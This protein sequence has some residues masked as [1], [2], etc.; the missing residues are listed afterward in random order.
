[1]GGAFLLSLGV[2]RYPIRWDQI[3]ASTMDSRVFFTLRLPRSAMALVAG[4]GLGMAGSVYQRVLGN[5]LASPDIM[6]VASGATVGAAA[7]ILWLGGG[8][9]TTAFAAFWGGMAAVVLVLAMA[10]ISRRRGV[11]GIV[12]AG[13]SVQA[14]V[15]A[16]LMLMK[17]AADP[18]KELASIEFWTM[19][20]F[21]GVTMDKFLGASVLALAG[22]IGLCLLSRPLLLLGLEEDEAR[23]LGVPV[24]A[25]R[26]GVLLLATLVTGSI[27]SVTGLIS[28]VGLLAPHMAR[29]ITRSSRFSTTLLAAEMGAVLLLAADIIARS[30]GSS[31]VPVSI[32]TSLLGGPFLFW[33]LCRKEDDRYV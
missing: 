22:M 3:F 9:L 21:A 4:A 11:M 14:V 25:L 23:M 12:L 2:G 16:L 13:I 10:G 20:S 1:M 28:F 19:G 29:L 27:V 8:V 7:S 32:V 5:P 18:E 33:L 30:V 17:L 15:Q 6:G 26:W 24:K 31:E